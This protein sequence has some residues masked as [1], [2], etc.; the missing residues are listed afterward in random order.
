MKPHITLVRALG[1][2]FLRRKLTPLILTFCI[3]A[4]LALVATLWLT[5]INVWWWLLAAPVISLTIIGTAICVL[6]RTV[7][8]VVRPPISKP[9]TKAVS[10]YVDKLERV[11]DNLQTPMFILAFRVARDIVRPQKQTFIAAVSQDSTTLHTDFIKLIREFEAN[12]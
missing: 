7:L 4:L 8:K 1:V 2:E 3:A 12:K 10:G 11:A 5:T 9:Q 6:A